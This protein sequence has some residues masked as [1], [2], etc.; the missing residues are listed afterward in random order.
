MR[1]LDR[2]RLDDDILEPPALALIGEPALRRPR[3]ADHLHRLV[4]PLGRLLGRDAEPGKLVAAVALADAKIQAAVRQQ[5]ECGR[6]L[7]DEDR[8]VPRQHDDRGA[9]ADALGAGRQ[10]G[11]QIHR[12]RDLAEAGE[13]VL[14][15]K[16]AG[17]AE[18]LGLDDVID[19]VV[20][21]VA[22]AGRAAACAR[23]AE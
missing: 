9:E 23:P 7:G 21:G 17:E 14:D 18:P 19:E 11:E 16:D 13:M 6:L 15:E 4:E 10:I 5:I 1:L 20:I 22:V 2:A 12:R 8:V 3:L